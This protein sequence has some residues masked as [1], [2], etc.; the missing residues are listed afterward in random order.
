MWVNIA[1]YQVFIYLQKRIFIL[2]DIARDPLTQ[3]M[4]HIDTSQCQTSC[5]D[6]YSNQ[7]QDLWEILRPPT[8]QIDKKIPLTHWGRVTHIGLR[9]LSIIG[10]D[11]GLAPDRRHAIIRT[12][13]AILSIRPLGPN[14]NGILIKI[15][16]RSIQKMSSGKWRPFCVGLRVDK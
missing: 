4:L 8:S 10:S 11:D 2:I 5:T 6:P 3:P 16:P 15:H 9:K 14:F 7:D 1:D 13:A 12:N